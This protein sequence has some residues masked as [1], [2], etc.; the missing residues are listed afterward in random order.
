ML[1]Q[2]AFPLRH[3]IVDTPPGPEHLQDKADSPH[4]SGNEADA[5]SLV[6]V[7]SSFS[8]ISVSHALYDSRLP[9]DFFSALV[10]DMLR[11]YAEQGDV[12]MAVSVLIVLG[13]RV[14]KDID[15]QT[16]V[17]DRVWGGLPGAAAT[18]RTTPARPACT[19]PSVCAQHT[20]GKL[21]SVPETLVSYLLPPLP[22]PPG[23]LVHVLHRPAAAF[24]P[25]ECVQPGGQAQHQPCHQLPQPGLH[26]PARQL[27]SLQAAHEQPGLGLRQVPPLRQHVR[28]LP[29]RGQGSVRVVPGL[30]SRRTPAAHHEVAGGQLPLPRR[31]RPPVRVLLT[32][33]PDLDG[34]AGLVNQIKEAGDVF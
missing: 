19:R 33:L 10:C 29:P 20:W 24:L 11:F 32:R 14:R 26:H 28:R 34:C 7:D 17:G 30:Q 9:P 3:E 12:Q 1:P 31:M 25:L 18:P 4:V 15:E 16:Q 22:A 6:P 8:L 27:Q 5:A 21:L 13:E 23:A 2:E